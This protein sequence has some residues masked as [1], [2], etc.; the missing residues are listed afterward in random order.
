MVD[1]YHIIKHF[2]ISN[3]PQQ[4]LNKERLKSFIS[5]SYVHKKHKWLA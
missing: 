2:D 5:L 3:L 4:L 1:E